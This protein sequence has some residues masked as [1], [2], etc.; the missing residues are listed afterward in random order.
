MPIAILLTPLFSHFAPGKARAFRRGCAFACVFTHLRPAGRALPVFFTPLQLRPHQITARDQTRELYQKGKRGVIVVAPTGFGKTILAADVVRLAESKGTKTLF[1]AHREELVTQAGN[2]L[3]EAGLQHGTIMAGHLMRMSHLTQVASVQTIV[4]RMDK[5]PFRPDFIVIDECHLSGAP[6]YRKIV[7]FYGNPRLL[8]LSATPVRL[9]GRSLSLQAGGL[10]DSMV[11][12]VGTADLI[13]EGFLS[14]FRY[15]APSKPDLTGI[16]IV[17][18][19][20]DQHELAERVD[21][22]KIVGDVV[23]TW[24]Q[25]A[26]GRS[27]IVFAVSVAHA[28]HIADEF[29]SI[30]VTAKCISG[31]T[32]SDERRKAM[33]DFCAGRLLVL[34]NCALYIEG[35]DAPIIRCVIL[36]SPTRSVTRYLQSVGRGL[37]TNPGKDD[38]VI[39]D[40]AGLVFDHG[41]PDENRE[42]TL[43]TSARKKKDAQ[44][45]LAIS[46]CPKCYAVHAP[47]PACPQCGHVYEIKSREVERVDG[48]LVELTS[49]GLADRK[50]LKPAAM[51]GMA[52]DRP[53]LE[54]VARALGHQPGW[55]T[56]ILRARALKEA[57]KIA[58][59]RKQ[60]ALA[61]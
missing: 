60:G 38:C 44:K 39:L 22:P 45:T 4:R 53:A 7:E 27:T 34:V 46:Q 56:Y 47:A 25:R 18:G 5:I 52:K 1:M 6:T 14:P 51:I 32:K 26:A 35:I 40:H 33:E 15:F 28:E 19:D 9:D 49:S 17:A 37:R 8:G 2:K 10:F 31:Q 12:T 50:T 29:S 43:A 48:Q 57:A 21:K 42:W 58:E 3:S 36:S 54:K 16:K 59:E 61:L 41:L 30:G 20:Y 13:H 11:I 24:M 23:Q 55:V